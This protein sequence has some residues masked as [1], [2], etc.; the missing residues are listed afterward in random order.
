MPNTL[1]CCATSP[2]QAKNILHDLSEAGIAGDN[3]SLLM[4]QHD[5]G[6]ELALPSHAKTPTGSYIGAN[7]GGAIGGLIGATTLAIPGFGLL[8]AAGPLLSMLAGVG[9][10]ASVGNL[11]GALTEMGIPQHDALRCQEDIKRG[12]ILIAVTSDVGFAQRKVSD[13]FARHGIVD[14]R[15]GT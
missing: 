8:L 11:N 7:L 13:I 1:Y 4:S 15:P 14:V 6:V 9:I 5:S 3:I 12:L 2:D 10:G